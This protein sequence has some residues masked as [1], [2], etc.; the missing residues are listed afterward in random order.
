ME[1]SNRKK[2]SKSEQ[3]NGC[4]EFVHAL[5]SS[6]ML[7]PV[8]DDEVKSFNDF[9]SQ[10]NEELPERFKKIDFLFQ[11]LEK[12][13][14]NAILTSSPVS[15]EEITLAYAARDGQENLPKHILDQMKDLKNKTK[16]KK[17]KGSQ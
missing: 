10:L 8:S 5:R 13:K 6:G 9:Y 15:K 12:K 11:E 4:S 14:T 16:Q 1:N 7:L 17:S 2:N 3:N